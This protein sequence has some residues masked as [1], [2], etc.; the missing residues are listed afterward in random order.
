MSLTVGE[1]R[2]RLVVQPDRQR[3]IVV[4]SLSDWLES[5]GLEHYAPVF[6]ENGVD[7]ET[8]RLLT[9]S[10]LERLGLLLGH[11]KKLLKAI[12]ELDASKVSPPI[13]DAKAGRSLQEPGSTAGERRQATVMFSDLAGYTAM[14]ERLDPEEVRAIVARIKAT[15][16]RIVEAQGGVINQ[17]VGDEVMALFGI[18]RAHEDDAARAVRAA[19]ELHSLVR[20]MSPEVEQRIGAP[21]RLHTGISSGL[22]VT[23]TGDRRDGTYGVTGDAVNT[24]AR[25][26]SHA[27]AD[28]V[29]VSEET[30]RLIADFFQSEAL[31]PVE[32]KGKAARVTPYRVLRQTG[33]SSR[34]EAAAG[35]G[36]TR[37]T[38]RDVELRTLLATLQ[39]TRSG[40]GQFV[41]VSGE[42]GIGKSRLLFEFRHSL[43]RDSVAVLEGRCQS[44]ATDT[45]Y[46]P[47]IDALRRGL[48]FDQV[49]ATETMH[50]YLV[51]TV[52]GIS[53]ELER[54]LP[55]YL[56]LCSIP[57]DHHTLPPLQGDALRRGFEEALA[58][59]LTENARQRPFVLIFEDWHWA[60]EA[61]EAA[62]RYLVTLVSHHRIQLVVTHRPEYQKAWPDPEYHTTLVLQPL[63]EPETASML[64]SAWNARTLPPGLATQIHSRCG[65][66]ALFTEELAR[67]LVERGEIR[68]QDGAVALERELAGLQLPNSL[69]AVIGARV[70]RLDVDG[71]EVLRLA[72]VIGREFS[73]GLLEALHPNPANLPAALDRLARAGLIYPLRIVPEP[74]YLF[75]HALVQDVVYETLLLSQRKALHERAGK[76][77]ETQHGERLEEHYDQLAHHYSHSENL[78]KAIEYLE[79]AGDKS[80]ALYTIRDSVNKYSAVLDRLHDLQND[81]TSKRKRIEVNLKLI[82]AGWTQPSPKFFAYLEESTNYARELQDTVSLARLAWAGGRLP[83]MLGEVARAKAQML[84]ALRLAKSTSQSALQRTICMDLVNICTQAADY[85]EALRFSEAAYDPDERPEN[86]LTNTG[87]LLF[88]SWAQAA[89]GDFTAS[90]RT[91]SKQH[92]LAERL[93]SV[94]MQAWGGFWLGLNSALQG[95]WGQSLAGYNA[96]IPYFQAMGDSYGIGLTTAFRGYPRF[97]TGDIDAAQRD[98][99]GKLLMQQSGS[100]LGLSLI[101]SYEAEMWFCLGDHSRFTAL[102]A[103]ALALR[104]LGQRVSEARSRFL[105][106]AAHASTS[107]TMDGDAIEEVEAAIRLAEQLGERPTEAWAHLRYAEL[108]HRVGARDRALDRLA[109]AGRMFEEMQMAWWSQQAS[110]VSERLSRGE[111]FPGFVPVVAADMQGRPRSTRS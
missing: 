102:T 36:L 43:E 71:R 95:D 101:L 76:A 106:A 25:L 10:D 59:L 91:L 11:R 89:L 79:K 45:P 47:F 6:T 88:S 29:L 38:G 90:H 104:S 55:F 69:H 86:L 60:D 26:A 80:A 93:Q 3:S 19:R 51:R 111:A 35:R 2:T 30:Q 96:A 34:F 42:P 64:C 81:D 12:G 78:E 105:S 74:A 92:E 84:E 97:M 70:D 33:A 82:T 62:L 23:N 77:I 75:K 99:E 31:Q 37:Y 21:L 61:S 32:L 83:W 48:R 20:D 17:F 39:Q 1:A 14:N 67:Q 4:D 100:T 49:P 52:R 108:L 58:A 7:I 72:S 63:G 56:H 22:I 41:T 54:F 57:S 53:L 46:L 73:R 66:N 13:R 98:F 44:E 15:A 68:V 18:P 107:D 5:L 65:G 28:Q 103:E 8:V 109:R 24:G 16:V 50:D 87:A 110:A 40:R 94:F 9:E 27:Q 85:S